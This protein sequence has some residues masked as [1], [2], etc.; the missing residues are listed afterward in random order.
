MP[1][2]WL[3]ALLCAAAWPRATALSVPAAGL[4]APGGAKDVAWGDMDQMAVDIQDL[5]AAVVPAV[6]CGSTLAAPAR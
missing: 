6:G 3:C 4:R 5:C 1:G 2:A